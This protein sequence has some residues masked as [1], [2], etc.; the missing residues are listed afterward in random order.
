VA[1][2]AA[3]AG[4]FSDARVL[5]AAELF[6]STF[7]DSSITTKT[8]AMQSEVE[9]MRDVVKGINSAAKIALGEEKPGGGLFGFG[10][11][12]PSQAELAQQVRDLYVKGGTAFNQY[13][14]YAN[15][16]LPIQLNKI[17]YL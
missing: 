15:E 10:A 5:V 16:G 6:A 4:G 3:K 7:S 12:V 8:K 14:Y 13:A 11:N 9:K 17:P 2:R 1:E